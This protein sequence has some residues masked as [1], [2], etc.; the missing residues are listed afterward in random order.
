MTSEKSQL[1]IYNDICKF[2]EME[3]VSENI[4]A[5]VKGLLY[6]NIFF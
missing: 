3:K 2:Q 5:N 6:N 4:L 1:L